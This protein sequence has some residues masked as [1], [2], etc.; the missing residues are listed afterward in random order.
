MSSVHE[1]FN[2][3]RHRCWS[4]WVAAIEIF[5]S[6]VGSSVLVGVAISCGLTGDFAVM[7][8]TGRR[9]CFCLARRV[10][11]FGFIEGIFVVVVITIGILNL[12]MRFA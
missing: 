4:W 2:K 10:I 6:F 11:M 5:K 12:I 3:V 7:C 1:P 8:L 9:K